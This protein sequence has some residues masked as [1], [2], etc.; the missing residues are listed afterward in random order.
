M[1]LDQEAAKN[2]QK[3]Y[4]DAT[5]IMES[6][7]DQMLKGVLQGTQT[8]SQAFARMA[9]NMIMSFVEA[10]AKILVENGLLWVAQQLGFT[11]MAASLATTLGEWNLTEAQKT[12]TTTAANTARSVSDTAALTTGVAAVKAATSAEIASYAGVAAAASFA[13][14][15]A[16][17]VVGWAMAPGVSAEALA[18]CMSYEAFDVGTPNVPKDMLAQIHEGEAIIPKHTAQAWRDGDTQ[19]LGGGGGSNPVHFHISSMD[20]AG[21]AKLLKQ[22]GSAIAAGV[23][24]AARGGNGGL[25]TA[26][27]RM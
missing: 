1:K 17:P 3:V 27:G 2:G 18:Q 16:I 23:A 7:L 10:I 9:G 26:L 6:S 22:H 15:A 13:S 5:K 25:R 12:A 8:I 4:T 21:V 11:K 19:A 24:S 20:S 14:V